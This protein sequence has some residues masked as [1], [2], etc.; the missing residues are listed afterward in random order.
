MKRIL[1]INPNTN[2]AVTQRIRE[3]ASRSARAG[4]EFEVINP[5]LGPFSIE[6]DAERREAESHVVSL[7]RDKSRLRYDAYVMACFDDLALPAL[8]ALVHEPVVG[9]CEAAI[10]AVRSVSPYFAIVTTVHDA[11]PG[12]RA[13]MA[14]YGAGPFATVRAAGIGVA[15]AAD[16][17]RATRER[18]R[19]AVREA[20]QMDGAKAILL[21]SGGLTG[22]APS[23][24]DDTGVPVVDG[25]E[26]ALR[27]AIGRVE[28]AIPST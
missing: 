23:V 17:A 26:A 4:I 27:A 10:A 6:S 1:V 9:T 15:E 5:E 3:M 22:Q 16:A 8:R 19:D 7:V 14:R 18:I 20:V 11:V 2:T 25:V 13:L 24:S 12:I 21:A 28:Q